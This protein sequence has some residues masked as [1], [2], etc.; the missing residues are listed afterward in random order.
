MITC[1]LFKTGFNQPVSII[2]FSPAFKFTV[3][4]LTPVLGKDCKW[5]VVYDNVTSADLLMP[6]WPRASHGKAIITTRNHSLAFEPAGAGLEIQSWDAETG[7][8]FL[9]FLLKTEIG[10]DLEA[11]TGSALSLSEKLSGHALALSHMAGLIHRRSW[12]VSEFMAVYLKN[13]RRV[14]NQGLQELWDFSF[15]S[16]EK[17]SFL[18]LGIMS[19]LMP[20][21]IPQLLFDLDDESDLPDDLEFFADDFR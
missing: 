1:S 12:S 21:S 18:F 2:G 5:L 6:Y 15:Q 11:E 3:H 9:L 7:S 17:Q 4:R 19:Y 13:P 10:K 16:L 14:H 20:D 8:K